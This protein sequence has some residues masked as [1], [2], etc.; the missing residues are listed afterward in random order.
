MVFGKIRV[1]H[2]FPRD[3]YVPGTIQRLG[4]LMILSVGLWGCTVR[5][6]ENE[7]VIEHTATHIGVAKALAEGHCE[8]FGK[9]AR[10]V[11]SGNTDTSFL[12]FRKK[13]SEF[14]CFSSP[15]KEPATAGPKETK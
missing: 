8:K 9:S 4:L 10:L 1:F 2:L 15:D 7:F 11:R 5:A 14:E 12:G 6:N 13:V 3:N